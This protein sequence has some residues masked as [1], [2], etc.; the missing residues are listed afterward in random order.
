MVLRSC[1]NTLSDRYWNHQSEF[2]HQLNTLREEVSK[3]TIDESASLQLLGSGAVCSAF[4]VWIIVC[5]HRRS[6][7]L[8]LHSTVLLLLSEFTP[9][10]I[11]TRI[12]NHGK[13]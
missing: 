8:T 9:I 6:Y 1:L 5:L 11:R 12:M 3:R 4:S 7:G 10:C 2:L 13:N